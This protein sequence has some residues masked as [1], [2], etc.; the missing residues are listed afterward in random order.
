M[1]DGIGGTSKWAPTAGLLISTVVVEDELDKLGTPLWDKPFDPTA[2]GGP[3]DFSFNDTLDEL[4]HFCEDRCANFEGCTG[5]QLTEVDPQ[6]VSSPFGQSMY[7][8]YEVVESI[9]HR[10]D[11][12]GGDSAVGGKDPAHTYCVDK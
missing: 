9:K 5:Y 10:C 8:Y 7:G 6:E 11:I 2:P 1:L 12:L 4:I 3:A